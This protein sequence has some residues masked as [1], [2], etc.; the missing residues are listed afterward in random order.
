MRLN[1]IRECINNRIIELHF[2]PSYFNVADILTKPLASD[3]Y[4]RHQSHLCNGIPVDYISEINR[5]IK[6]QIHNR[7][8]KNNNNTYQYTE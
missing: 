6:L 3:A 1:F 2:I 4:H 8:H 7:S 5:N